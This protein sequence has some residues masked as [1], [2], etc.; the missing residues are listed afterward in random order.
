MHVHAHTQQQGQNT[1]QQ[2]RKDDDNVATMGHWSSGTRSAPGVAEFTQDEHNTYQS[3]S[4]NGYH[5]CQDSH[6]Q[7]DTRV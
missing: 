6:R 3:K 1:Q 7:Q 4:R 2:R 5:G